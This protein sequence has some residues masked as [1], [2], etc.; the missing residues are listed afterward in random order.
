MCIRDSC[1]EADLEEIAKNDYVLTP[2]RYV[3]ASE[4]EEDAEAFDEKM[5]RLTQTL[6]AQFAESVELEEA[7]REKLKGIGYEF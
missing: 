7:I 6:K 4:I 1:Y 5:A 3:G 2:G